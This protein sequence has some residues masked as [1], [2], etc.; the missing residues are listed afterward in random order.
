MLA[1]SSEMPKVLAG[2]REGTLDLVAVDQVRLATGRARAA[3]Q[4]VRDRRDIGLGLNK[5]HL[6]CP[7]DDAERVPA[8]AAF[9]PPLGQL[10]R[11]FAAIDRREALPVL[12]SAKCRAA[13]GLR[14]TVEAAERLPSTAA[15][16]NFGSQLT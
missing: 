2:R 11:E 15:F 14:H 12:Y 13:R 10:L 3:R 4:A 5:D 1:T 8:R 9:R 7:L 6:V 16:S